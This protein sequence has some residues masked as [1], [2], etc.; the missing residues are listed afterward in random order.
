MKLT[1]VILVIVVVLTGLPNNFFQPQSVEDL[2]VYDDQLAA[3]WF[4]WSWGGSVDLNALDV[5]NSG[6]RSIRVTYEGWGGLS[7]Y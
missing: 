6:S 7:F 4:N 5:V 1:S 2:I 3:N